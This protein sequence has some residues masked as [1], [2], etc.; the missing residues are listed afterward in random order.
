MI[1]KNDCVPK[2]VLSQRRLRR[3]AIAVMIGGLVVAFLLGLAV[4]WFVPKN[5]KE[6]VTASAET[7]IP[8]P[9]ASPEIYTSVGGYKFATL[10]S[11]L[12]QDFSNTS[13]SKTSV[14]TLFVEINETYNTV[15]SFFGVRT[16]FS[17]VSTTIGNVFGTTFYRVPFDFSGK[18]SN[19]EVLSS[20]GND[21]SVVPS[22]TA[23][24]PSASSFSIGSVIP[25][26]VRVD[27]GR[28]YYYFNFSGSEGTVPTFLFEFGGSG[29]TLTILGLLG[30]TLPILSSDSFESF[31][32]PL[33][34]TYDGS[35]YNP[36]LVY[37]Q[38]QYDSYG[39]NRYNAGKNEGY[40]SGYAAGVAAGGN[41]NF[42]SLITAVVDAPIKA[43]TSLLDFDILG[44]NMKNLALALLTAGL[45]IAAIRFFSRL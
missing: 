4:G 7:I 14:Y 21:L 45:L 9:N 25:H 5:E 16:S 8:N 39:N 24:T 23:G 40:N 10:F 31:L 11:F 29:K 34:V 37:T 38:N 19:A 44:Y 17:A 42:M 28:L 20:L 2:K 6:K 1:K 26:K 15:G 33:Y 32:L 27:L 18:V 3:Q 41:N 30:E 12:S 35:A 36:N 43:F 22:F 13:V